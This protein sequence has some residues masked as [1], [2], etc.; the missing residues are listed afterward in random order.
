MV[1]NNSSMFRL[2][3]GSFGNFEQYGRNPGL[4]LRRGEQPCILDGNRGIVGECL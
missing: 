3:W 4:F 2:F 1:S